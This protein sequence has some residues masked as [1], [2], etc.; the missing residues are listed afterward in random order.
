MPSPEKSAL[1]DPAAAARPVGAGDERFQPVDRAAWRAWL[2]A[3]HATSTGIWAVTYR[4]SAGKPVVSYDDLVEE[5]LCFGWIDSRPGKLDDERTMLRFTP[6]KRGSA[7]SRY[8][9][10]RVERLIANGSM[11]PAGLRAIE[12]ARAD[13][14][15]DALNDVDALRIPGDLAAALAGDPAAMRGFEAMSD[16]MKKPILFWV[17][18]ARREETRA[19]RIAEILRYAAVGRSPLEWPRRPLDA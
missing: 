19:R 13:G 3:N 5:A 15:W 18:S 10:E 9:K 11:A 17:T 16:S 1:P 12:A 2:T 7:W 8:N 14:S 6:R 4:R